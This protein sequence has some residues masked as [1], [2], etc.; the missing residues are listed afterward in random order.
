MLCC[1]QVAKALE[2][3]DYQDLGPFR[4]AM[5]RL[6]V[7]L[8]GFCR[9]Y[10]SHV[11]NMQDISRNFRTMDDDDPREDAGSREGPAMSEDA[12]KRLQAAL[13]Q[14]SPGASQADSQPG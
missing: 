7:H 5:L 2:K 14:A 9:N 12:M 13:Q 4:K 8:C 11:M 1:K 10:H 3:G 6:H